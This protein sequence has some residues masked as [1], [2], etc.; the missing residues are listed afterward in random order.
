MKHVFVITGLFLS[1][2]LIAQEPKQRPVKSAESVKVQAENKEKIKQLEQK[3]AVNETDP[4]YPAED[5]KKE[6]EQL[7]QLKSSQVKPQT[8]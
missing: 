4:T 3:I 7:K 1:I 6:K 8:H 2:G 5:L